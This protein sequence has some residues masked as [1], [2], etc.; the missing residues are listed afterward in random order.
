MAGQ[1]LLN[2]RPQDDRSSLIGC[3][4]KGVE[5]CVRADL[6]I[7]LLKTGDSIKLP[8]GTKLRISRRGQ[9]SAVFKVIFYTQIDTLQKYINVK[10]GEAEAVFTWKGV[11]VAG[12]VHALG[13]SW[14]LEGCGDGCFL[15]IK[16]KND[17]LDEKSAQISK[18]KNEVLQVPEN[19]TKLKVIFT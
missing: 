6:D 4:Q 18:L 2:L 17:W 16:Q 10:N 15:W 8:D 7:N 11:H 3:S 13:E 1:S 19:V 5:T 14:G 9:F 12:Q